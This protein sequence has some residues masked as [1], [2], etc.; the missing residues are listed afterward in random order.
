MRRDERHGG[1][2]IVGTFV[3]AL[4]LT[5]LPL[6]D[7]A[8]GWRPAWVTMVLIYWCLAAPQKMGMGGAFALGL[9]LDVMTGT[10]LGQNAFALVLVAYLCHK[11]YLQVRVRPPWQQGITV[12]ILVAMVKILSLWTKGVQGLP[13]QDYAV[14]WPA[15]TSTVLWPWVFVILRD[16]RRKYQVR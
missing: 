9:L 2:A 11:F 10:L 14:L 13:T 6:P 7:W 12:F 8:E 5:A 15:I 4:M 16:L 1:W 3:A